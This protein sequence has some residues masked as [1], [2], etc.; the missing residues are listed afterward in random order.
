MAREALKMGLEEKAGKYLKLT[1]QIGNYLH[2]NRVEGL[3]L[4]Y[5]VNLSDVLLKNSILSA[6]AGYGFKDKR[7]KGEL[8]FLQYLDA[9]KKWFLE[10]NLYYTLA[11]EE[12]SRRIT[13]TNNTFTS[14]LYKGD[15][16]DY[17]YKIG[18]SFGVG[19]KITDN[20]AVKLSA[21]LQK[22]E[23]AFN[24]TKFSIFKNKKP[25]RLNPEIAEGEFRG[26]RSA[27][28]YRSYNLD[29]ELFIEHTNKNILKSDFSYTMLRAKMRRS[30]RPGYFS[31]LHFHGFAG[32]STGT[33]TPQRWF[34]FGGKTFL[35][36][37]GNLR[38]AEYK[39]FTGD[40]AAYGTVEYSIQG[41]ALFDRGVKIGLLK[42]LKA[43]FWAGAGWSEL[44]EKTAG[45]AAQLNT[46]LAVTDGIYHEFGVG[47]GDILNIFRLDIIRNSISGNTLLV[48]FNVLQ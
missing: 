34:D 24:H 37:L 12:S 36:Y 5:G 7:G 45:F 6:T 8:G 26:L 22:E 25:F 28:V 13:T 27:L 15:Y 29:A 35:H 9:G 48:T 23:S 33:L 43:T 2:Y 14:L 3:R 10:E 4:N 40:A 20:L 18:G 41:G 38:G 16:R 44:S 39:E 17:Y 11:Y 42:A 21:L 46:P 32:Y 30:F 19:Y 31:R 47:L 1:R